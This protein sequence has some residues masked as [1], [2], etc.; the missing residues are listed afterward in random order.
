MV[1][2]NQNFTKH[3]VKSIIS[4]MSKIMNKQNFAKQF[5]IPSIVELLTYYN[6][7]FNKI[8]ELVLSKKSNKQI[9][10][11]FQSIRLPGHK[12]KLFDNDS[13]KLFSHKLPAIR[14]LISKLNFNFNNKN[15]LNKKKQKGGN[16]ADTKKKVRFNIPSKKEE[17]ESKNT[18]SKSE[19]KKGESESETEP[20]KD[21]YDEY[22]ADQ[23]SIDEVFDMRVNDTDV[24]GDY[25]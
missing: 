15:L 9:V 18:E 6:F 16:E 11:E 3:K 23:T 1:H 2:Y 22:S 7:L 4:N 14:K 10:N 24:Y 19:P 5:H 13:I 21:G 8:K 17:T 12:Q 20:K 25:Y